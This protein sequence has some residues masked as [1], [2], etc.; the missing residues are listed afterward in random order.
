MSSSILSPA[1]IEDITGYQQATK[2]L[3][4]LHDRGFLRAFINRKGEVV[5]E[6]PHFEAVSRG[7]LRDTGKRANL[8]IFQRGPRAA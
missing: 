5:L 7:E 8:A 1:E 4:V 3:Q 2:Q 6:R